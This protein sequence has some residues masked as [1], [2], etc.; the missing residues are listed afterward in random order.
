MNINRKLLF[1]PALAVGVI[2]LLS[3]I[4]LRPNLPVKPASDRAQLVETLSL[5][6]QAIAPLVIGFGKVSPKVQWKAISEVSGKVVYRHPKLEK[7]QVLQQGTEILRIDPLDYELKLSQ[8]EADLHS[9]ETSLAQLNQQELNLQQTLKI[10]KNRLDISRKELER[11]QNLLARGLTSQSDLDQQALTTLS[12][13]QMVQD[14]ENQLSLLPAEKKVAQ[15]VVNVNQAKLKEAQRS[16]TKT[17]IVLPQTLRIAQVDVEREQVTNIQQTMV[18]AH[19][20]EVMEID[21]QFS[22]HD[23]QT[24]LASLGTTL[25]A[26]GEDQA[27]IHSLHANVALNSGRVTTSWSAQVARISETVDPNQATVGVILEVKQDA[28]RV[29]SAT[30]PSLVNGMFVKAEIEG[31]VNPSWVIPERALHG[32]KIYLMNHEQRL[33]IQPV[34][35]LYRRDGQ[36]VISGSLHSGSRLI[37]NDLLPAIDGMLL[38]EVIAEER[39]L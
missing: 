38:R 27:S 33:Q 16:L 15:A 32:D 8:A 6:P 4:Y 21:A 14:I 20:M 23:L 36:V 31:Q 26:E 18:V 1:F 37:L 24:L 5:K 13:Q 34:T 39:A 12:Q 3:A 10:E 19:S 2:A 7:G 17:R 30:Q 28:Q 29:M 35:V 11:K 22:I 25:D 9:S